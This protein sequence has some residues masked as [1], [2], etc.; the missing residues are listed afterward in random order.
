MIYWYQLYIVDDIFLTTVS[1]VYC[2]SH[3]INY[4]SI[5]M[6]V[7]WAIYVVSLS[8]YMYIYI[9]MYINM[10]ILDRENCSTME[11][12]DTHIHMCVYI[13]VYIYICIYIYID[14][15]ELISSMQI[16]EPAF[17]WYRPI[18]RTFKIHFWTHP[19]FNMEGRM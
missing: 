14:R 19:F 1:N 8:L 5:S 12:R 4:L 18:D 11:Q 13:Y 10:Y 7:Y 6:Y 2:L 9:C 16:S 17:L 15:K 3:A